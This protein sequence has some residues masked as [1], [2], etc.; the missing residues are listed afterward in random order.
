MKHLFFLLLFASYGL[1]AVE[2]KNTASF[3]SG[4]NTG[5]NTALAIGSQ[6][7]VEDVQ[8]SFMTLNNPGYSSIFLNRS[9]LVTV[10]L[11]YD[12]SKKYNYGSA[13]NLSVMYHTE[14]TDLNGNVTSTSAGS[15]TLQINYL[16]HTAPSNYTDIAVNT[17]TSTNSYKVKV[18]IDNILFNPGATS[19]IPSTFE[20]IYL[21]VTESTE[22][23]Y[24]LSSSA[25]AMTTQSGFNYSGQSG[26]AN[27]RLPLSWSFVP[28]AESYD[29]EWLHINV[30][31]IN[32]FT[33]NY[34]FDFRD[35]VRINLPLNHYEIPLA[36]P[37]GI[38]LYRVRAVGYTVAGSDVVRVEGPWSMPQSGDVGTHAPAADPSRRYDFAGLDTPKNW[39]YNSAYTE[40]GK[41][42][43][44]IVYSDGGLKERQVTTYSSTDDNVIVSE[45]VY[46]YEGRP[47][48]A[49]MPAPF[50]SSGVKYYSV[51]PNYNPVDF[52][53]DASLLNPAAYPSSSTGAGFVFSQANPD[54]SG[55]EGYVPSAN[56]YPY[57]RT[58]YTNDGTNRLKSQ[59]HYGD[60]YKTGSNR[61]IKYIYGQPASQWELDRLFGTE[62]GNYINYSKTAQIDENGQATINYL[63]NHDRV[64]ATA[65]AGNAPSNLREVDGKPDAVPVVVNL[66]ENNNNLNT[67]S[68]TLSSSQ[69]LMVLTTGVYKFQYNLSQSQ[70]CKTCGQ[71]TFCQDCR[72]D[73]TIKITDETGN[74]VS[75]TNYTVNN[76]SGQLEQ[77]NPFRF[78]NVSVVD[79]LSFDVN[80]LPGKY[81][82]DKILSVNETAVS[83]STDAL[84][85]AQLLNPTCIE[86]PHI[87]PD[88]CSNSCYEACTERY[89]R[90]NFETNTEYWVNDEEEQ[91]TYTQAQILINNCVAGCESPKAG[92]VLSEC[93]MKLR[94]LIGDMKP[95]GQYFSNTMVRFIND[96]TLGVIE[97][98]DYASHEFDWLTTNLAASSSSLFASFSALSG[99][100]IT[101]WNQVKANW[102]DTFSVQLVK[103]HPEYCAYSYF[104]EGTIV[105]GR[106]GDLA[107]PIS[108]PQSNAFD[109][110][111]NGA[112]ETEAIAT[113]YFNPLGLASNNT[114]ATS[115]FTNGNQ[116]YCPYGS[117][118]TDPF[119]RFDCNVQFRNCEINTGN[120]MIN[121][122]KKYL[123]LG[124][125]NYFSLWYVLDDPDQIH[126]IS[127]ASAGTPSQPVIDIFKQLH[128]DGTTANPGLFSTTTK[129]AFFRSVYTFY[130]QLFIYSKYG[131][132]ACPA[133]STLNPLGTAPSSVTVIH[134]E[135]T[136]RYTANPVYDAILGASSICDLSN[137]TG[138]S[139][140]I[141]SLSVNVAAQLDSSCASSCRQAAQTWLQELSSCN[142]TPTVLQNIENYLVLVCRKGC[143]VDYP[144][145]TSGCD[146][147]STPSCTAVSGPGGV[148]FYNFE[149]VISYF[150]A[151]ACT[152]NIVHP[153]G[154]GDNDCACYNLQT[155]ITEN[156]LSP[157]D[158]A[159]IAA[160]LNTLYD[161]TTYVAS[162]VT[163]WQSICS[164]A[165]STGP[166]LTAANYP[167]DLLCQQK[168]SLYNEVSCSCSKLADFINQIGY[169]ANDPTKYPQIVA[170][171]NNFFIL[172]AAQQITVTQ[173]GN[174]LTACNAST[175]PAYSLFTAN[176][177][178][179]VL[180]CPVPTGT[181]Q[182]QL[183]DAEDMAGCLQ[184]NLTIAT[185][186]AVQELYL[187]IKLLKDS[188]KTQYIT[189]CLT[190]AKAGAETFSMN[191]IL[192]EYLYTLFYYDQAGNLVKTVPPLGVSFITLASDFT[193]IKNYRNGSSTI[194]VYPAHRMVTITTYDSEENKLSNQTPDEGT[195]R[196][197]Y[198]YR[199]RVILS[200]NSRQAATTSPGKA[201]SYTEYDDLNRVKETRQIYNNS[202]LTY[203]QAI[204]KAN[205]D[206]WLTAVISKDQVTRYYYDDALA[207]TNGPF[208]AN[209]QKNIT[210][211]LSSVTYL[212][213]GT[214]DYDA[215]THF[216]YDVHGLVKV[217]AQENRYKDG[218]GNYLFPTASQFQTTEYDYEPVSG[219]VLKTSYQRGKSDALYQRFLYDA[220]NR[221]KAVYSSTDDVIWE[222]DA[223]Y[224]Y[225]KHGPLS[226]KE[227]GDK[228]VQGVDYAYTINGW[229]KIMNSSVL[230]SRYD[231]GKDS[232]ALASNLNAFFAS[233]AFGFA[234]G[235]F[236][237]DYMPRSATLMNASVSPEANPFTNANNE[238]GKYIYSAVTNPH[239]YSLYD[240]T[241]SYMTQQSRITTGGLME[242]YGKAYNYDQLY[243][244]KYQ[245]S[246]KDPNLNSTNVWGTSTAAS[247]NTKEDFFYD[248]NGN[249]SGVKRYL[250]NSLID[251]LKYNYLL[252]GSNNKVNNKL[253][254]IRE[255]SAVAANVYPDDVDNQS[256]GLS[257]VPVNPDQNASVNYVYN[258]N[259]EMTRDY[260][261][262]IETID[263]NM[264][265]KVRKITRRT[266]AYYES[267]GLYTYPSDLEYYYDALGRR[268]VK[269]EMPRIQ[270][271]AVTQ[272]KLSAKSEWKYTMY[273]YDSQNNVTAI[274]S[275]QKN[276]ASFELKVEERYVYGNSRLADLSKKA[277]LSAIP[278][279]TSFARTLGLKT[280]ELGGTSGNINTTVT[281]YKVASNVGT[282]V[283]SYLPRVLSAMDYYAYGTPVQTRKWITDSYRYSQ[284]GGSEKDPEIT[285]TENMY[286]TYFRELDARNGRWWSADPMIHPG[287]SPYAVNN[288]NPIN[289]VDPMGDD[290]KNLLEKGKKFAKEH[291]KFEKRK[292]AFGESQAVGISYQMG[293][294]TPS[295]NISYRKYKTGLGTT[296]GKERTDIV[297]TPAVAFGIREGAANE[298]NLFNSYSLFAIENE[299]AASL[300]YGVNF[301]ISKNRS[302]AVGGFMLKLGQLSATLYDDANAFLLFLS[303]DNNRYWSGGGRISWDARTSD[304]PRP[305]VI[306]L[307]TDVYT[308]DRLKK[309]GKYQTYT[310]NGTEYYQQNSE[311]KALN[312]GH[313]FLSL[314][315]PTSR[316]KI[317]S[318]YGSGGIQALWYQNWVH[319]NFYIDSPIFES[320]APFNYIKSDFKK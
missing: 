288:N 259:G 183:D 114:H 151:N 317:Y 85:A 216:S 249:I 178:P 61:E 280:F 99:Q 90:F 168:K 89:K 77:P 165:T 40:D 284:N 11:R 166:M 122:F 171:I 304:L 79:N 279:Y 221:V 16:S 2:D 315:G 286:T 32:P 303:R 126:L 266:N 131:A 42:S 115:D 119:L 278:S 47:A 301:V 231:I 273:A 6:V 135:P 113:G 239:D 10:K 97:N 212:E 75:A 51:N 236:R 86:Y 60:T 188:Y 251:E 76:I 143:S 174:I 314:S 161:V 20:D 9:N 319:R 129:W 230:D 269:I 49:V 196:Y 41:R 80:L 219:N 133:P 38:I 318:I 66:L 274:Y 197:W 299:Y 298:Q 123:P 104:C 163:N 50:P 224:F 223:R 121:N 102:R 191:Y 137:P 287:I 144:V 199:G 57:S 200:Q 204:V 267:G 226:R 155:F 252:D 73:L 185:A 120:Y 145:G 182:A 176:N 52:D 74:L 128:G 93:T 257:A 108:I 29:L 103:Y 64:I 116:T 1:L 152:V 82:V 262:G 110:L 88:L 297:I 220:D 12:D 24:V 142:L 98:P 293:W 291:I 271:G 313:T 206:T 295:L 105:C 94:A 28:G 91:I 22:R 39:V 13:W 193:A 124:N 46:D 37:K 96:P 167:A 173:L 243:R 179:S 214:G 19:T 237:G 229:L 203:E 181:T 25:P 169:D 254:Y 118:T 202:P 235:Y 147:V 159:A 211:R 87:V 153:K 53:T 127:S 232:R 146:E 71:F 265:G 184:E 72:Y 310:S 3:Q 177:V 289:E 307:G 260:I 55:V 101:S 5:L 27:V 186:S 112:T 7:T 300:A 154:M 140:A 277:L 248:F 320:K 308:G 208:V 148:S 270:N 164:M 162:D 263:Y 58:R 44:V 316:N 305:G 205:V 15:Y 23:Y 149:D 234:N 62:A 18:V 227:L 95:G 272:N 222:N 294:F 31:A 141:T 240:G 106:K 150:T 264:T 276:G 17:H 311:Q 158:P 136:L 130:K 54:N 275:W 312:N 48:I 245:E 139:N 282:S 309:D 43:E 190:N 306:T 45:P 33:N 192:N 228:Q 195:T 256:A 253:Y 292:N 285:R 189:Q 59:T 246:F 35:A 255:T 84:I 238:F 67:S 107:A 218:N 201:Y 156:N 92:P 14:F 26:D 233:D 132:Y 160:R 81:S 111:L 180:L 8:N 100:T 170:A 125:G 225:Y 65:L 302:Q 215:A 175:P 83:E 258:P 207:F 290:A 70:S 242:A 241:I 34:L 296:D 30:N 244:L 213:S 109:Q 63:D 261:E 198:D 268:I 281:D 217:V 56:A 187:Q 283:A 250:N 157:S 78:V 134:S 69:T 194:P 21:D 117:T 36:F 68:N 138:L 4:T 209:P 247:T 172:P 210:G